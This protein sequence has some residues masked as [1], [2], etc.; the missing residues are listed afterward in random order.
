M[1]VFVFV[2]VL[3]VE[4]PPVAVMYANGPLVQFAG[5]FAVGKLNAPE[6]AAVVV[7][8]ISFADVPP[9]PL[10]LVSYRDTVDPPIGPRPPCTVPLIETAACPVEL[11]R[12]AAVPAAQPVSRFRPQVAAIA[13]L[14]VRV[15]SL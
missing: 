1:P 15:E 11:S 9:Y 5:T 8:A 4:S 7:E 6:L 2:V 10:V 3:P 12:L 14:R 13:K